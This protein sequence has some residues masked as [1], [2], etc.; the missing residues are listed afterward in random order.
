MRGSKVRGS[1]FDGNV[2]TGVQTKQTIKHIVNSYDDM[3]AYATCKIEKSLYHEV[4]NN[5]E[6]RKHLKNKADTDREFSREK[7]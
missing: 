2:E 1:W 5:L 3:A 7:S 6:V 4:P